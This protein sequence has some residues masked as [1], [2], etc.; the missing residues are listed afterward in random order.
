MHVPTDMQAASLLRTS[1]DDQAVDCRVLTLDTVCASDPCF[2]DPVL[3][4]C[5]AEG[6]EVAILNGARELIRRASPIWLLEFHPETAKRFGQKPLQAAE[7]F[8]S[9]VGEPYRALRVDEDT[10]ALLPL[11]S[12]DAADRF[13]GLFVPS[14]R[15]SR[16]GRYFEPRL[17]NATPTS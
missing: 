3:V 16:L 10:G 4:K 7:V 14:G 11:S 6:A 1:A 13:N 12:R 9:I 17:R 5:D 8:A 2:T 15:E